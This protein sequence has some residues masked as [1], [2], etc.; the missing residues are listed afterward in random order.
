MITDH[1]NSVNIGEGRNA[2]FEVVATGEILLYQWLKDNVE[3]TNMAGSID[4]VTTVTLVL[5]AVALS[6]S[7]EYTVRVSNDAGVVTS[8]AATLSVGAY[9]QL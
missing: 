4:G 2:K 3:L 9:L 1:P 6:D 8:M 5:T 7:G